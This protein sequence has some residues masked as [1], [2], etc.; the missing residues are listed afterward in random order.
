MGVR[1]PVVGVAQVDV[2][3]VEGH[4]NEGEQVRVHD[5]LV[6]QLRPHAQLARVSS[7]R[8]QTSGRAA[9]GMGGGRARLDLVGEAVALERA[10]RD[11]AGG[12]PLMHGVEDRHARLL[13]E[14][15]LDHPARCPAAR[16][17]WGTGAVGRKGTET[18][19]RKQG[20]LARTDSRPSRTPA[21][22]RCPG[23]PW[24][25]YARR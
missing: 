18:G 9:V 17:G 20:V 14:P 21:G 19:R 2:L 3:A 7:R 13:R 1:T 12:H 4:G 8:H 5:H 24:P 11:G 22:A 10:V 6:E 25:L 15:V 16:E 23:A